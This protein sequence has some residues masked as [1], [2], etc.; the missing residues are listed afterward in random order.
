MDERALVLAFIFAIFVLAGA[1]KGLIGLGLP[2]IAM[3]LLAI[4]MPP[5]PAAALLVVPTFVTNVWQLAFGPAFKPLLGRL[6]PMLVGICGGTWLGAGS[7]VSD[8]GKATVLALGVA[9]MVYAILGLASIRF[10]VPAR[11]ESWLSGAIGVVT[12]LISAATGVFVIP[13]GPYLQALGLEKDDLV[14]ALGLTFTVAT[15]A[16]AVSL[17]RAGVLNSSF[18]IA[19][20]LALIPALLGLAV[21]QW[22]R[23]RARPEVFRMCFLIGLL[24]LGAHLAVRGLM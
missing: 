11:G 19:S 9:L 1:V 18:A 21:G 14:Q 16:L 13:S 12:G 5:A 2:T 3:G 23:A 6:W 7:L 20:G 24:L 22:L 10:T 8:N 4:V 17:A 15:V